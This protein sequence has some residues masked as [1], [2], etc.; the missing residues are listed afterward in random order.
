MHVSRLGRIGMVLTGLM[1]SPGASL[2]QIVVPNATRFTERDCRC[3]HAGF[4]DACI[5]SETCGLH[6]DELS[7][8][9]ALQRGMSS[10]EPVITVVAMHEIEAACER[11]CKSKHPMDYPV[12]RR[13]ICLP[14]MRR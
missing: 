6:P 2:A 3:L 4:L 9:M 10:L 7:Y 12:L 14:L 11:S 5:A 8:S 1:L 13:T